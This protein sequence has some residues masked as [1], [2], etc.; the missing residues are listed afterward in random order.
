MNA[1]TQLLNQ[2]QELPEFIGVPLISVNQQGGW[3]STPLHIAV[4]R[5]RPDEV[6]VFLDAG[7]DP[8]ASGEYGERPIQVAIGLGNFGIVEQL[9]RAGAKCELKD[10][11]GKDAWEVAEMMG[12]KDKLL[13]CIQNVN[14]Q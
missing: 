14:G 9:L 13:N 3:K 1:L 10:E 4:Y 12:V 5:E 11:K 7:A 2:Y 8:N 6:R